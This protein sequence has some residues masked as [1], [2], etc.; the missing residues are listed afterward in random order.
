MI[1]NEARLKGINRILSTGH[2]TINTSQMS[3]AEKT[4]N[5]GAVTE[6]FGSKV[7]VATAKTVEIQLMSKD[8]MTPV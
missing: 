5:M 1:P 6:T 2:S 3:V 4:I 8:F 7:S